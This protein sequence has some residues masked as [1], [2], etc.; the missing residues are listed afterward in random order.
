MTINSGNAGPKVSYDGDDATTVFPVPFRFF[1]A[2]HLLVTLRDANGAETV[3][4]ITTN[5]TVAGAGLAAGGAVTMLIAPATGEKLVIE[6]N[7]PGTQEKAFPLGGAFPSTQVEKALDLDVQRYNQL[8][9]LFDR[10]F[11]VPTSDSQVGEDLAYPID[12]ERAGAFLAFDNDGKPIAAAGTSADL[13]PVSVFTNTLLALANA[14][15]WRSSLGAVGTTGNESIAGN[16]TLTGDTTF[17]GEINADGPLALGDGSELTI[18]SGSITPTANQHSVDTEA[19]AAADDL[20][21]IA[22]T[23]MQGGALLLLTPE[24]AARVVTVKHGT[25]NIDLHDDTDF[26]L[27]NAA[28]SLLL[29]LDGSTWREVVRTPTVDK[30]VWIYGPQVDLSAGTETSVDLITSLPSDITELEILWNRGA[31][32][33]TNQVP[34]ARIGPTAGVVNTGYSSVTGVITGSSAGEDS[35]DN[36]FYPARAANYGANEQITGVMRLSRWDPS[37]HLWMASGDFHS[38]DGEIH[39]ATVFITLADALARVAITTPGGVALLNNG[40]AR[41]RYR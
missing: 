20:A 21:T 8:L 41:V 4:V 39:P 19:D 7:V 31:S 11:R 25:G 18:A 36:G 5:Y 32:N 1:L 17:T 6:L 40:E 12:S 9:A 15:A 10:V 13:G 22:T 23:N 3:Q 28:S 27:D 2:E 38:N 30:G 35:D 14:A 24:N 37:E 29:R 16:K 26:A 33:T 34:I